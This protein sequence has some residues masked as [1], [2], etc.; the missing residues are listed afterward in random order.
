MNPANLVHLWENLQRT[1]I[2]ATSAD[3]TIAAASAGEKIVVMQM[4]LSV[5]ADSVF[6]FEDGVGGSVLCGPH[7]I[8]AQTGNA[9]LPGA[10]NGLVVLPFSPIGWFET[11]VNTLLNLTKTGG[12]IGGSLDYIRLNF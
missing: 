5:D 8:F 6:S 2:N 1:A 11:S 4:I 12:D 7:N 3:N 9:L 10:S